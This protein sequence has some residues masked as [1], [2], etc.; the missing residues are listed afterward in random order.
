[1]N[2]IT[3]LGRVLPPTGN[4]SYVLTLIKDKKAWNQGNYETLED[5]AAA[6]LKWD[7]TD[8][9]VYFAVGTHHDNEYQDDNGKT[10]YRRKQD[11]AYRFKSLCIDIDVGPDKPYQ[12]QKEAYRAL[13][14]A[15][16]ALGI[17]MPT[18]VS[19]GGGLHCYWPLMKTISAVNW[20]KSGIY[21][22]SALESQGVQIDV[23]KVHDTSM[24][25]RPVETTH[26]KDP[27][28]LRP[29]R[30]LSESED[31][32]I[33]DLV[34]KLKAAVPSGIAARPS[35]P[36]S[37]RP[38][39]PTIS[40]I[41]NTS[42]D[43]VK[44]EHLVAGCQVI[45]ALDTSGGATSKY[46]MWFAALN[47]AKFCDDVPAA[48]DRLCGAHP[49]FDE[50]AC[51]DK[52]AT[53]DSGKG[54]TKCATF[55]AAAKAEGIAGCAGC[56]HQ[57]KIN[58]PYSL[59]RG[60]TEVVEPEVTFSVPEP[61]SLKNGRIIRT[62][63]DT[64]V[65]E[66]EDGKKKKVEFDNTE[67]VCPLPMYMDSRY[68]DADHEGTVAH[69]KAKYP[70][71]GWRQFDVPIATL[72]AG[73]ADFMRI[74]GDKEIVPRDRDGGGNKIRR[75]LM[76]YLDH[77]QQY[78][79]TSYKYSHFG[80]HK[81]GS[82]LL[83]QTLL[84]VQ[85]ERHFK[86]DGAAAQ[87]ADS[88]QKK[89]T[90]EAWIDGTKLLDRDDTRLHGCM[91]LMGMSS[92]IL[93][94]STLNACLLHMYSPDTG[95]GKSALQTFVMSA[96][97][98]PAALMMKSTDTENATFKKLGVLNNLTLCMD[99]MT[100]IIAKDPD[101]AH[102]FAYILSQG[103]DK[104]ALTTTRE[105][106][107]KLSWNAFV[108]W[109]S[110]S[111]LEGQLDSRI[112]SNGIRARLFQGYFPKNPF[113]DQHGKEFAEIYLRNYGHV[114]ELIVAEILRMGGKEAVY[115]AAYQRFEKMYNFKFQGHERFIMAAFVCAEAV[116]EIAERLG[117][118][119]FDG[120]KAIKRGLEELASKR[121]KEAVGHRDGM[122]LLGQYLLERNNAIVEC[123][124]EAT[125]PN[126]KMKVKLPTPNVAFVRYEIKR[127]NNVPY[128]GTIHINRADLR[129]W[130]SLNG[131]DFD[132]LLKSLA[133][134]GVIYADHQRVS[135]MKGCDKSNPGQTYCLSIELNHPRIISVLS[136]PDI[137]VEV[138]THPGNIL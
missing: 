28:K 91:A 16:E 6:A 54:M 73:G 21:L 52:I 10:K 107:E 90:L 31:F 75:Y 117:L 38:I 53:T 109:S 5:L 2:L 103:S 112:A 47:V 134:M 121:D 114:T 9:S 131:G 83:G 119:K 111:D 3:F 115:E 116:R 126:P 44:L 129:R 84:G 4:G 48:V 64:K 100:E 89:G 137:P 106:R 33:V 13:G 87:M 125:A 85:G 88:L 35:R 69:I 105:L 81:D 14:I 132:A 63:K 133:A 96:Y 62:F 99:E 108:I 68:T 41:L 72:F 55:D 57:G 78:S 36:P 77:L 51:L 74:L 97:G 49:D 94:G 66:D 93:A 23:S 101:R 29:V 59:S 118:I 102:K 122:D 12:S 82:F 123:V 40:N 130:L 11:T 61:Y 98:N 7:K 24:V 30:V 27:S 136:H 71:G 79:D 25:L 67:E 110:N 50:K 17:P 26:K 22:R 8:W 45:R 70:M 60:T 65:V 1:M 42:F 46:P 138:S 43:K 135:I 34:V 128:D 104:D 120:K 80:W 19:S 18:V 76:S 56:P 86:L 127:N 92:P 95:T 32:D 20:E 15:L 58:S 113:F 37:S 39:D 124:E